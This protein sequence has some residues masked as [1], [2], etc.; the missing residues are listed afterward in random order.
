M[1]VYLE[2]YGC[3]ANL[4]NSEIMA[5]ILAA[6]GH[7]IVNSEAEAELVVL[8]SCI[9]KEPTLNKM[10]SRMREI[11]PRLV[12]TGCLPDA[13]PELVRRFQPDALMVG[14]HHVG[15]I[16]HAIADWRHRL[17]KTPEIKLGLPRRSVSRVIEIVQIGEGCL[18]SC[19]YCATKIA[20]GALFSYPERAIV[21]QIKE[22]LARNVRLIWLTSQD[23]AA[24][25]QEQQKGLP[26]LLR[27]ILKLPGHFKLRI[28]MLNPTFLTKIVDELAELLAA[29]KRLFSFA[30]IPVQSGSDSVLEAMSRGYTVADFVRSV[31]VLRSALPELQL[32]TDIIC[33]FPSESDADFAQSLELIERVQ[34]DVVHVNRFWPMPGTRAAALKQLPR[35]VVDARSKKMSALAEALALERNRAWLNWCGPAFVDRIGRG[36]AIARNQS[37]KPI[38]LDCAHAPSALL[39]QELEIE[40]TAARPRYLLG[41]PLE[42]G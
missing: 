21:D 24:W 14:V 13:R 16:G 33:G 32:M 41:R 39:G 23:C 22:V 19:S 29:D 9:V 12:V 5:G 10:I 7:E 15:E 30:H 3:S 4:N 2:S 17:G 36:R 1:R 25:G 37:Y 35:A 40:I 8:N 31:K 38:V 27:E 18:G 20:K 28:G 34:P 42:M 11:K 6:A 26:K